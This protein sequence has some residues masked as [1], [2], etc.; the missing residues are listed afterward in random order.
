MRSTRYSIL[1]ANRKTGAVRRF[2]IS[3]R[4]GVLALI[5]AVGLVTT[6]LLLGLGAKTAGEAELAGLRLTNE[7]LRLENESYREATGELTGQVASLQTVLTQ[8]SEQ[9]QLDPTTKA[10]LDKLPQL[11]R[12]RAMG[13]GATRVDPALA[14]AV[15]GSPESTFGILSDLLGVLEDRLATVKTKIEGQQAL[16]RAT[17]SIWPVIPRW[18]SSGFGMR[19]DPFTGRPDFH[20]GL[21]ISAD[22]GTPVK[23][24]ADGKIESA[25][26]AGNYGNAVV[27]SH[28]FG[29]ATR[30]GHLSGFAVRAG[31][32]VKR[33][34]V[35]GFV[36][37]TGRATNTHLHYEILLNGQPIN[38]LRL[39]ARP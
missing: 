19:P 37:S 13:G 8:L 32:T 38:P 2:S 18:L 25:E 7:I 24:T 31:Q 21:D 22:H 1:I 5:S 28:G 30:F 26:Y 6:P 10:A 16:A 4:L 3:R 36:G 27:I 9:S 12:G 39:L 29:I 20:S 14:R 17:P 11:L 33:G 34:D 23:A 35:V 15:N